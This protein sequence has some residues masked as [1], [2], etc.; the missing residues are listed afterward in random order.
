MDIAKISLSQ[1]LQV[2]NSTKLNKTNL[3]PQQAD[4][5]QLSFKGDKNVF[6]DSALTELF[7]EADAEAKFKEMMDYVINSDCK[8]SEEFDKMKNFYLKN[9]FR[10]LLQ[11]LWNQNQNGSLD[12]LIDYESLTLAQASENKPLIQIYYLGKF[13]ISKDSPNEVQIVFSDPEDK[14]SI[15]FGLNRN[16][17]LEVTQKSEYASKY[18]KF[19]LPTGNRKCT[20]ERPTGGNIETTYYNKDGQRSFWKNFLFGGVTIVPQ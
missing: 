4:S 15:F 13:D 10:G 20:V 11:N 7:C 16:C 3:K 19:H 14:N 6:K 8:K 9:G 18:T 1:P 5:F 2:K 12:N 17:E